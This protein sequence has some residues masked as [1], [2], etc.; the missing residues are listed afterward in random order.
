V[1]IKRG[2][3]SVR[4]LIFIADTSQTNGAGLAN[5][6][7][8]SSGLVAYYIAG[9]LNNEVQVTLVSATLGTFTSGGFVAVDNTNMPGWYEI[10]IP[11][12]ALDGG[13][14]VAIQLRGATNM[15]PVNI[16]IELD[17]VDYQS[18]TNFGLSKFADIETDTQDIQNRLPSGLVDG[19]MAS[20]AQVVGDKTGYKLASDG[21]SLVTAWAVAITGNL[22]GNVT[23]SVGSISGVT[24]PAN[25]GSLGIDPSG[26]ILLVV[27]VQELGAGALTAN[28][29]GDPIADIVWDEVLTGAT[30]NIASSAGRRLRQLASVIVRAGTAQG[31]GT[32]NNQI[33]LD[34]GASAT[35]GEYDPGLIFIETG[36]G[37]GQARLILQYNGSTKVATVDRDWRVNPDNTSEFVILAD[38]GRNSVN[39]GLAQGGTSTTITLNASAS[40][41]DDAYNGQLV[42]IRSGTG[43]DQV[44]LVEDYV[45]STKVATIRTRSATGQWAT[46]PDTT[47]AYMMIP[48]L[49]FTLSE[50]SGAVAATQALSRLDSMIESDGAGQFRF[51]TIALENAPAG[52]GGGGTDWTANERTAIRSILGIPTSGTTPTDPSSGILDTIRDSVGA[53]GINVYPVS[54]STPE[55]VQGTTLTFYR[56]ESRSVSVVTDFTLTSLTLQFTV[57]DQDGVDVYTL[58]NGSISRSGQTFTVAVTTAVTG[59]LGQ[60]RWSMRDISGGGSSVVAMGVLTVQEAASNV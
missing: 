55:R 36:T 49:T 54:A 47:S 48:N 1:K 46:V 34:A 15:A 31:S 7:F 14:E 51:D 52:G 22:T 38:A 21:L 45:G 24:F 32:G 41:S 50:I 44:G 60:Y 30:H 20:I 5:L 42:F 25:F 39:E 6:V 57:E 12:A 4:R 17:A 9:D 13:N 28:N 2:S 59:N 43:Q 58:A 3:T 29:A 16:Y 26:S 56:N 37:A 23:G 8:N 10:G 11:D 35:N 27:E 19:R 53:I 18:A 33:Q 40:S